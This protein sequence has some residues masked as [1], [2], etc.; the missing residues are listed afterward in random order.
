MKKIIFAILLIPLVFSSIADAKEVKKSKKSKDTAPY[1]IVNEYIRHLGTMHEIQ[2]AAKKE[3]EN[4]RDDENA[5]PYTSLLNS[6]NANTKMI[7]ELRFSINTLK[8]MHISREHFTDTLPMTAGI[9]KDQLKLYEESKDIAKKTIGM[10][11][12][13]AD[14]SKMS[15][16]LSRMP[17]IRAN[18]EYLDETLFKM[19][20]MVFAVLIDEKPDSE[21]HMSHLNI[22]IEQRDKLI[23]NIDGY[24]G[25]SLNQENKNYI[26]GSAWLLK[27]YLQKDYLCTNE[28]MNVSSE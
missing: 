24:F 11:P 10:N 1:A 2:S 12:E 21:G 3:A 27:S 20:V 28:W 23:E 15:K 16:M 6:I 4:T 26:V 9:Y 8:G 22:S 19:M 13:K 5:T 25:D 14:L 18:I 7:Y 17:E